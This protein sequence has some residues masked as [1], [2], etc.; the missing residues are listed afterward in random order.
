MSQLWFPPIFV[1]KNK[2]VVQA[3]QIP[4]PLSSCGTAPETTGSLPSAAASPGITEGKIQPL[5]LH[6]GSLKK[7]K[8]GVTG[9]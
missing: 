3:H 6:T 4:A 5:C 1:A 8:T 9:N 2:N 7:Q